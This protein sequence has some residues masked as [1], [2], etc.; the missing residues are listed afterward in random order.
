MILMLTV[1]SMNLNT[2][3]QIDLRDEFNTSFQKGYFEQ[4][5][6]IIVLA[7]I[8]SQIFFANFVYLK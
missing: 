6:I 4:Y 5:L 8:H 1:N 7:D 3:Y 2:E